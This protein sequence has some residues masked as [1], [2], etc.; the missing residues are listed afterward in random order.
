MRRSVKAAV[1]ALALVP[2]LVIAIAMPAGADN[3]TAINLSGN[4]CG[5]AVNA[6]NNFFPGDNGNL[7]FCYYVAA[8]DLD[9][10]IYA[11][12]Q[13]GADNTKS[14]LFCNDPLFAGPPVASV[15]DVAGG[16]FTRVGPFAN[17]G[18]ACVLKVTIAG[19]AT[20]TT[21]GQGWVSWVPTP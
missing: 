2:A 16:S 14:E 18:G 19:G 10:Y 5:I 8:P 12:T 21:R 6:G 11:E 1:A 4:N 7:G 13:A 20:S 17:P 3:E 15:T 9:S